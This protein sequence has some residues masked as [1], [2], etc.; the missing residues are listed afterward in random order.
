MELVETSAARPVQRSEIPFVSVIV[1]VR[2][3]A[4]FLGQTLGQL[5]TQRYDPNRFEILVAD[6]ES[7]DQTREVVEALQEEHPN[8]RLLR[9][10]QRWSSAGRNAAVRAARGDLIVLVDGHCELEGPN[11]LADLSG[12]VSPQRRGLLRGPTAVLD[13][14][15][16]PHGAAG[17]RSRQRGPPASGHHPDSHIWSDREGFVPPQ[18]RGGGLS[19]RGS[20]SASACFDETFDACEDVEFNERV[21]RAS[22]CA[23]SS[24]LKSAFATTRAARWAD[25]SGNWCV[26]AAGASGCSSMQHPGTL[27]P[28]SLAPAAFLAGVALGPLVC[29]LLPLWWAYFGVLGVYAS[30]VFLVSVA[31]ALQQQRPGLLPAAAPGF[32]DRS[33]RSGLGPA[34]RGLWP[35]ATAQ[36]RYPTRPLKGCEAKGRRAAGRL[37][38]PVLLS[39][40]GL[41]QLAESS[42]LAC[43]DCFTTADS[44]CRIGNHATWKGHSRCFLQALGTNPNPL[45]SSAAN[46]AL[47]DAQRLDHR[48]GGLFPRFRIRELRGPS[49]LARD[50]AAASRDST[51]A[52]AG[53]VRSLRRSRPPFSCSVGWPSARPA[54]VL[55]IAPG[56]PRDWPV[57]ATGIDGSTRKR[58]AS[59]AP[60]CV[61]RATMCCKAPATSGK[62][63]RTLNLIRRLAER[64]TD[65]SVPS[66]H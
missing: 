5:L 10:P 44:H 54:L 51:R 33:R 26:T 16:R 19:T 40:G 36:G 8:L 55:A 41:P 14:G 37:S 27:S 1:P 11:Y 53:S 48:R 18:S 57:T 3:E 17:R 58:P 35:D 56:R 64:R 50:A 63:I 61:R 32:P 47:A 49:Q 52:P 42:A 4:A 22:A 59:S 24:P 23:V 38:P 66:Q 30:I 60:T 29:L 6:G 2:N 31:V 12:S 65:M 34:P 28:Q 13:H 39:T 43:R 45:V 20:S 7:T 62:R 9:T 25:C 21:A 46:A 15:D